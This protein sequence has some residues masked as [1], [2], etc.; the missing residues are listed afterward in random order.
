MRE[1]YAVR[2]YGTVCNLHIRTKNILVAPRARTL[3]DIF[4]TVGP[5]HRKLPDLP[6]SALEGRD[7]KYGS[8]RL[9]TRLVSTESATDLE[10]VVD[11]GD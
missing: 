1:H 7:M 4:M 3:D 6:I 2:T 5:V 9:A 8:P 10:R 11:L